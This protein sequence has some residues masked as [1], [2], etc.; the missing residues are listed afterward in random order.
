MSK[1][2]SSLLLGMLFLSSTG[3]LSFYSKVETAREGEPRRPVSFESAKA[4]MDFQNGLKKGTR[5]RGNMHVGVLPFLNLYS[6]EVKVSEN[7]YFNDQAAVCDVNQDGYITEQEAAI[8]CG[9]LSLKMQVQQSE[10]Q[11]AFTPMQ[12]QAGQAQQPQQQQQ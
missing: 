4:A 6:K 3:C 1:A 9:D 12:P 5:S 11:Q 2:I 7:A 10:L 8:F